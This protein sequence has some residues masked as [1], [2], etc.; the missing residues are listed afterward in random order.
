VQ[1]QDEREGQ[2]RGPVREVLDDVGRELRDRRAQVVE[3][4][5]YVVL[6]AGVLYLFSSVG[7]DSGNWYDVTHRTT[8]AAIG[9][10]LL[11]G[12]AAVAALALVVDGQ[13]RRSTRPGAVPRHI[14]SRRRVYG[15]MALGVALAAAG[16]LALIAWS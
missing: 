15:A 9:I 13:V 5:A 4:L 6:L 1:R 14:K 2:D 16:T 12:G 11:L 8:L 10:G 7:Q 3:G